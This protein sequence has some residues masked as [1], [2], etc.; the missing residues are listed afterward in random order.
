M[1][2]SRFPIPQ[3]TLDMLILQI[4]LAPLCIEGQSI[5]ERR[6]FFER[7]DSAIHAAVVSNWG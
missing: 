4:L 1:F 7:H 6:H 3:G 2:S 5:P